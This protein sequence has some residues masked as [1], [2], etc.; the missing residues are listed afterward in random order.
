MAN[1]PWNSRGIGVN[2]TGQAPDGYGGLGFAGELAH[3]EGRR[4][5]TPG[6]WNTVASGTGG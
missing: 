5:S 4:K 1:W 2:R 3:N 6:A